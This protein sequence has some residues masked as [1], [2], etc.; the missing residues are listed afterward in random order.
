MRTLRQYTDELHNT[1]MVTQHPTLLLVE[2]AALTIDLGR[3]AR[4]KDRP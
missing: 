1:T 2:H 3:L 4:W